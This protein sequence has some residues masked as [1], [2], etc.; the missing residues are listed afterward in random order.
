[1]RHAAT[2]KNVAEAAG[3]STMTVTRVYGKGYVASATRKKV[4]HFAAKLN[5]RPNLLARGLRGCKTKSIGI[6][7]PMGGP[8]D[9]Q[10]L[11]REIT[12]RLSKFGYVSYV[13]DSLNDAKIIKECLIDFVARNIDGIIIEED[14][15]ILRDPEILDSLRRITNV[16]IGSGV[17]QNK[18]IYFDYI[19]WNRTNVVYKIIDYLVSKGRKNICLLAQNLASSREK[20]YMDA[21]K[22]HQL[23]TA[24]N[25]IINTD[26][27][28]ISPDF[29][30]LLTHS[31]FPYDAILTANDELAA[32]VIGLLQKKG[33]N[34]PR[35]V[36]VVGF[37]D[38]LM[39]QFFIPPI[40]SVNRQNQ[41]FA[42][43]AVDILLEKI[44]GK[45]VNQRIEQ[46]D[47]EFIK[48]ES[49]G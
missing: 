24:N 39:S 17:V 43:L 19:Q 6:L 48:R 12:F 32:A 45:R 15:N 36:A 42:N 10:G 25:R 3:V 26:R 38:N 20:A 27:F 8:H 34:V 7:W 16:M 47:M 18:D 46:I 35:D 13:V 30:S 44:E 5:Y 2:I 14:D 4:E 21:L 49:A 22:L 23:P 11:V 41:Q 9:S 31:E 1:M 29:N 33:L 28:T 40:A 37:N